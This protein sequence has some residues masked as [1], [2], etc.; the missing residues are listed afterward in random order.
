M[1]LAVVETGGCPT[2]NCELCSRACSRQ[3]HGSW[4]RIKAEGKADLAPC[5]VGYYLK[6][7]GVN[8][9]RAPVTAPK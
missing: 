6:P 3:F 7:V 1:K 5:V 9:V 2:L 8:L 4:Q